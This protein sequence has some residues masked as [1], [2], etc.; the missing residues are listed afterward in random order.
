V[1][2][3]E[4]SAV[5]IVAG[6]A[7]DEAR[8][9]RKG[10]EHTLV[11]VLEELPP[12]WIDGVGVVEVLLEELTDVP[13]VEAGRLERRGHVRVCSRQRR[14]STEDASAAVA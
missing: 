5:P 13:G 6:A 8:Q 7:A 14:R 2:G 9:A 10:C 12:G 4:R 3:R 11:R 1:R